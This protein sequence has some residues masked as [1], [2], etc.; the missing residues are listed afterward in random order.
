M[1]KFLI[2]LLV[3]VGG[4]AGY[5]IS[6][7]L[8]KPRDPGLVFERLVGAAELILAKNDVHRVYLI[9]PDINN[10]RDPK[11]L[12]VWHAT[13]EYVLDLKAQPLTAQWSADSAQLNVQ[14]PAIQLKTPTIHTD[15]FYAVPI[16]S[17]WFVNE[18]RFMREELMRTLPHARNLGLDALKE[19][20]VQELV[21]AELQ[22]FISSL[23]LGLGLMRKPEIVITFAESALPEP[24]PVVIAYCSDTGR[25][26][27]ALS[28]V[29]RPSAVADTSQAKDKWSV[30]VSR[31][32]N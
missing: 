17:R 22:S 8:N 29:M 32:G 23:M 26:P 13:L 3:I 31:R 7:L 15:E 19:G 4:I 12:I 5:F 18:E 30:A 9:C 28:G 14:A 11:I 2:A 16:Q 10:W 25:L 1:N 20:K 21:A 27:K 6:K 24:E